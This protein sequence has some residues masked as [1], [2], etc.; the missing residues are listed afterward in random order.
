MIKNLIIKIKY[1]KNYIAVLED[2][3]LVELYKNNNIYVGD[4]YIGRII[5][6]YNKMNAVFIDIGYYK[7]GFLNYEDI[8]EYFLSFFKKKIIFI[9]INKKKSNVI[10]IFKKGQYIIVQVI[11]DIIYNKGPKLTCKIKLIGRYIILI[12]YYNKKKIS[13]YKKNKKKIIKNIK[14]PKNIGIIIRT[15]AKNQKI[16]NIKLEIYVLLKIW[17]N[18]LFNIFK[19][20][21]KKIYNNNNIFYYIF[22]LKYINYNK[23]ICN[24]YNLCIIL[25]LYLYIL[26]TN[27]VKNIKYYNNKEVSIF[28]KYGIYKIKKILFNK[29]IYLSD[30]SNLIIEKTEALNVI[31]INS[32]MLNNFNSFKVNMYSIKEIVRQIRLRNMGGIIIIDLIK[33]KKN[34]YKKK[35]YNKLKKEME[36][37]NIKHK[38]LPPN[39]FNLIEIIREK[40]YNYYINNNYKK[41]II[42][43]NKINILFNIEYFLKKYYIKRSKKEYIYIYVNP[44][45][46]AYFKY[47]FYSYRLKWYIKYNKWLYIISN[48]KLNKFEYK[49]LNKKKECIYADVVE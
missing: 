46:A 27:Y 47:G 6:I 29:Y 9:K 23:I 34:K 13:I 19:K 49:I 21:I 17:Y 33:I 31:D 12:P 2:N 25:K 10:D 20:K 1:N 41:K 30:G 18:L 5:Y 32:N 42:Y 3:N 4:I 39:K 22:K 44:Y 8:G 48:Y 24:D 28:N 40:N 37:D 16:K 15:L 36:I 43:K 26:N 11:K 45:L 38:I 35:I 7:Y 14:L